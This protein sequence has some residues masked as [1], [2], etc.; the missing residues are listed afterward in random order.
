MTEADPHFFAKRVASRSSL[1]LHRVLRQPS[2]RRDADGCAARRDFVPNIATRCPLRL[3]V[4]FGPGVRHRGALH[5]E[6]VIVCGPTNAGA[7]RRRWA[8]NPSGS[9]TTGSQTFSPHA[10]APGQ[11]RAIDDPQARFRR[12]VDLNVIE[13]V[14]NLSRA[15]VV[16]AGVAA[17]A[18]AHASWSRLRPARRAPPR[19]GPR[20]DGNEKPMRS[21]AMSRTSGGIGTVRRERGSVAGL[22]PGGP[23]FVTDS[24]P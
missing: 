8:R 10:P 19:P 13:Q 7:S 14:Y 15:P 2:P 11:T 24:T 21:L 20:V 5:V 4:L 3:N 1:P 12:L 17:C 6:H 22:Q 23:M 18:E 9:L 16:Q